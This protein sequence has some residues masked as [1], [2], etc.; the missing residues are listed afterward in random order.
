M[1]MRNLPVA[2]VV[3]AIVGTFPVIE[4]LAQPPSN[5]SRAGAVVVTSVPFS[6]AEDTSEATASGPKFCSNNGSVFFKLHAASD[7]DLQVDTIGSGYDTVLAVFTNTAG[8]INEIG[9]NDDAVGLTSA[10]RFHADAGTTYVFMVGFCCGNGQSGGGGDL[11]FSISE[12]PTTPIEFTASVGAHGTVDPDGIAT[13][14]GRVECSQRGVVF[15]SGTVRQRRGY[16]FVAR[17]P[18]FTQVACDPG[19]S[20]PWHANADTETSVVFG[21]GPARVQWVATIFNGF[22]SADQGLRQRSVEIMEP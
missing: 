11:A 9:C 14:R 6:Y 8:A 18:F 15:I 10:V 12:T 7:Q 1:R 17:G 16:L 19:S 22:E 20:T 2:I 4:A 21:A 13:I 5:D 3:A